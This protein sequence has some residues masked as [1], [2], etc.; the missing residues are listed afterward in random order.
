[1]ELALAFAACG[2]SEYDVAKTHVNVIREYLT[3]SG[4]VDR[5]TKVLL[6]AAIIEG[7]EGDR[8]Y[9][10]EWLGCVFTYPTDA[11]GW[12]EKWPLITR[13]RADL[14]AELGED[15]YNA[16]WERGATLDLETMIQELLADPRFQ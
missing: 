4:S 8:E 6:V 13:L 3:V 11:T 1:V 10:T 2:L 5:R 16:A 7:N 12:M 14:R 9:A 15:A